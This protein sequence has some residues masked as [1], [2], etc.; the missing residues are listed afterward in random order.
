MSEPNLKKGELL[1]K[2][3]TH[4]LIYSLKRVPVAGAVVEL[5]TVG[6]QE[7][8]NKIRQ[9]QAQLELA[10]R[11]TQLEEAAIISPAQARE[12]AQAVIAE[13]RQKGQV[14]S[15]DQEAAMVDIA[16][17]M[18][19][20]ICT[21]TQAVLRQAQRYGTTVHTVLPMGEGSSTMEQNEFYRSLL[22][23]RRPQFREGDPVPYG[24]P[25]WRL[26]RLINTGGLG[27]VWE[28]RHQH[29]EDHFAVK[30]CQDRVSAKILKRE[31]AALLKLRED[32]SRLP[33]IV[34]LEDLQLEQEPYWLAFEYVNG[35]TLEALMRAKTFTW[36][37][38]LQLFLPL[39]QSMSV[40]HSLGIIHGDLKPANILLTDEGEPKIANFGFGKVSVERELEQ[41]RHRPIALGFS[42][43]VYISHEQWEGQPAHP[44]DD[45]FSLAVIFWQLLNH[46]LKPPR[47]VKA[48]LEQLEI[49]D[50]AQT[51]ILECLK[52]PREL[53]PQVA[54]ELLQSLQPLL[55]AEEQRW[56]QLEVQT[57][58]QFEAIA[59]Q[60]LQQEWETAK[61][62][63]TLVAYQNYF[64]HYPHSVHTQEVTTRISQLAELAAVTAWQKARQTNNLSAYE[65]YIKRYP[66][67]SRSRFHELN[68]FNLLD[69][70]RLLWWLCLSPWRL[71]IHREVF[72]IDRETYVS[73][74]LVSTLIWLPLFLPSLAL[75][76]GWL[77]HTVTVF[78]PQGYLL[79]AAVVGVAW[80]LTGALKG[81]NTEGVFGTLVSPT[82][83]V[84]VGVLGGMLTGGVMVF[85]MVFMRIVFKKVCMMVSMPGCVATFVAILVAWGVAN[86]IAE[87]WSIIIA[88]I[89]AVVV[90]TMIEGSIKKG[91]SSAIAFFALIFVYSFLSWVCFFN[92]WKILE[93]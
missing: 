43:T 85:V 24:N 46:T 64:N 59:Q 21:R 38:A 7:V 10:E 48:S 77:P 5:T 12:I 61:Q 17:S 33:N 20:T 37:E 89:V 19:A 57:L 9:E 91:S 47:Y 90:A 79:A 8:S 66:Q 93:Y 62:T 41:N 70:W 1:L 27:E 26:V 56:A 54:G 82:F 16:S 87:G 45:T 50:E 72:G 78:T 35:G 39:L 40:V 30:F 13:E 3:I 44:T 63:D 74:W 25:Q 18:P 69:W 80:L 29:L 2:R 55:P 15:A 14:I 51:L 32:L 31:A 4:S 23:A 60:R 28:A 58:S 86:G 73:S 81:I 88:I 11:I 53:R 34:R 75:G 52:L 65:E 67:E 68:A 84:A 6:W 49:P 71:Q 92:G 83:M 36:E 42:S 22:P 76:L